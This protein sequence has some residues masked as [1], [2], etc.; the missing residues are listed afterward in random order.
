MSDYTQNSHDPATESHPESPLEDNDGTS[1]GILLEKADYEH[2]SPEV[3]SLNSSTMLEHPNHGEKDTL[4]KYAPKDPI[5]ATATVT[6]PIAGTAPVRPVGSAVPVSLTA[7]SELSTAVV[8]LNQ[9]M[10]WRLFYPIASRETIISLCKATAINLFLPFINGVFLG[11]GE[12]CAHEL[13]FRWGWINSAHVVSVPGRRAANSGNV[14]INAAGTAAAG[15]A[16]SGAGSIGSVSGTEGSGYAGSR[17][18]IGGLGRHEDERHHQ[19]RRS[20]DDTSLSYD[21]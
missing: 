16:I 6:R 18:G 7:S 8:D 12:I 2:S 3:S 20:P 4:D 5:L 10:P 21:Y 15:A 9:T 17:S 1:S 11:F 19:R 14:G 13:A